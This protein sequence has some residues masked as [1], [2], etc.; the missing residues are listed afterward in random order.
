MARRKT[1]SSHYRRRNY[2]INPAFQWK[3]TLTIGIGMFLIA[4]LMGIVMFGT[5][6]QQARARV[7][8]PATSEVGQNASTLI[9]FAV[10]LSA[11]MV[12]AL[13]CWSIVM[14]HRIS[15]PLFVLQSLFTDLGK[16]LFPKRRPLRKKDEFKE[17]HDSFWTA[18]DSL[19]AK[20]GS[21]LAMLTEALNTARSA[22]TGDDEAR[23]CALG[24]IAAQIEPLCNEIAGAL[25]QPAPAEPTTDSRAEAQDV[26]AMADCNA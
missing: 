26:F 12:A 14:T 25:D 4:S 8:F 23:K 10:G 11:V 24:L 19:R 16:G 2:I 7:M 20:R 15:G 17:L 21:E 13:G 18:V 9:I 1:D 22:A 6:H 5:L 3:Y